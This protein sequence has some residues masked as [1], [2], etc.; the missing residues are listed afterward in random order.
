MDCVTALSKKETQRYSRQLILKE[1]G[2]DNHRKISNTSVLVVGLGGL[3]S[4]VVTYLSTSGIKKLIL[5]DF[6]KVELHNL[7]RQTIHQ[8]NF[9]TN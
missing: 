9:K 6:D 1:I 2:L 8:E 3:G 5:A 4:P 7:Q